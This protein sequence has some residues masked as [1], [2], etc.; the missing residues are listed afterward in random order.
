MTMRH[1]LFYDPS[2]QACCETSAD[3][4]IF[5]VIALMGPRIPRLPRLLS[6]VRTPR[7]SI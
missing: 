4:I 7:E 6:C 1:P 5:D 3:R 2:D